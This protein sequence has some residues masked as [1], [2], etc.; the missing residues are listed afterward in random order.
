MFGG[1][2][3]MAKESRTAQD[4]WIT[5]RKNNKNYRTKWQAYPVTINKVTCAA[6]KLIKDPE[7]WTVTELQTGRK[8]AMRGD[9]KTIE[10]AITNAKTDIKQISKQYS[11]TFPEMIAKSLKIHGTVRS[12]PEWEGS[13][14]EDQD[15]GA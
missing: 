10:D 11:T 3:Y 7:H 9:N 14:K 12:L 1:R 8:I 4:I 2:D 13:Y 5:V 15:K 6:H